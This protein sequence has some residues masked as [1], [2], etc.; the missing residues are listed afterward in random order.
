MYSFFLFNSQSVLQ[1]TVGVGPVISSGDLLSSLQ[2]NYLMSGQHGSKIHPNTTDP[3]AN[4]NDPQLKQLQ[5]P[6]TGGVASTAIKKQGVSAESCDVTNQ[7][8]VD[9][10]IPKYEKDFTQKQLIKDAIMDN[11][12]FK[13]IDSS[14]VREL[15]DSMYSRVIAKG[16]YVIREGEAGAH[17][18]VSV[19][20][21]FEVIKG[22]K[23]LG[24]MGPGKA[25]GEL[26][27][28]YN[29]T[30]T[31]SIRVLQNARVWVLDRRVFQ[32]IMM[33]TGMQRIEENVNFLKSV[34]LLKDLS[35]DILKKIADV[36]E[37]VSLFLLLIIHFFHFQF[38]HIF[39]KNLI[40]VSKGIL[41]CGCIHHT[42]RCEW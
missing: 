7:R 41:S 23:V 33:R 29:C 40:F 35:N 11:D 13:N 36:L 25:F 19:E 4:P 31:A 28:L 16:E 22:G 21:E 10:Q 15:V 6:S 1:K 26:A 30:R 37:V 32:Q 3:N 38:I 42:T 34:P 8:S 2:T 39:F 20:G 14:Q 24:I 9:I 17:L 18:Y 5:V 12:F 27:I